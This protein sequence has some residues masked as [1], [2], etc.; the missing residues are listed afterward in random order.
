[1]YYVG[2]YVFDL[3]YSGAPD[4]KIFILSNS[5]LA[6]GLSSLWIR[7][8]LAWGVWQS[9]WSKCGRKNKHS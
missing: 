3:V 2:H 1:M 7:V 9:E 5:V 8:T 4:E 6:H